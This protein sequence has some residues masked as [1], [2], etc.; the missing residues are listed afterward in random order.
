M[1]LDPIAGHD[2]MR[3]FTMNTSCHFFI[4]NGAG[5]NTT[6]YFEGPRRHK[7]PFFRGQAYN[8][9]NKV[10][11]DPAFAQSGASNTAARDKYKVYKRSFESYCEGKSGSKWVPLKRNEINLEP[12]WRGIR[13]LTSEEYRRQA[14]PP[15]SRPPNNVR[16]NAPAGASGSSIASNASNRTSSVFDVYDETTEGHLIFDGTFED[17]LQF[18]RKEFDD[19]VAD[20]KTL[21]TGKNFHFQNLWLYYF[22]SLT[23]LSLD[24]STEGF[25]VA[26]FDVG[27]DDYNEYKLAFGGVNDDL[28]FLQITALTYVEK[29]TWMEFCGDIQTQTTGAFESARNKAFGAEVAHLNGLGSKVRLCN[30]TVVW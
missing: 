27:V 28:L 29:S 12:S 18:S 20:A 19:F 2:E 7:H 3:F 24:M 21:G 6:P 25:V 4:E 13:K 9:R 11:E 5:H 22:S 16:I 23:T 8:I 17:M 14:T 26:L 1:P 10:T 30:D 15:M